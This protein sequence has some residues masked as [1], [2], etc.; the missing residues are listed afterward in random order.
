MSGHLREKWRGTKKRYMISYR[1]CKHTEVKSYTCALS[2]KFTQR[3]AQ[4]RDAKC[5]SRFGVCVLVQRD[6]QFKSSSLGVA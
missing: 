1:S 2:Q 6:F 3:S 4:R 5:I